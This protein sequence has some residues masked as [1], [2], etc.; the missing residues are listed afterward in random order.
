MTRKSLQRH[1]PGHSVVSSGDDA[2]DVFK[3]DVHVAAF[4]RNGAGIWA[5]MSEHHEC[6][7]KAKTAADDAR[8]AKV[9]ANPKTAHLPDDQADGK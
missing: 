1:F 2:H 4:R 6:D 8:A 9:K 3:G 5:D 7:L